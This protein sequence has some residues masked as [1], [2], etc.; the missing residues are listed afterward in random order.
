MITV[1][2]QPLR[3]LAAA[4]PYPLY[5][6]GGSVRDFLAGALSPRPDLSL[7]HI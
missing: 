6:V 7:I 4:L 5:A 2:P 3:A 1:I